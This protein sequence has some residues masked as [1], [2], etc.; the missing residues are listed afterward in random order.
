MRNCWGKDM[1]LQW[2]RLAASGKT[3]GIAADK[4]CTVD[5]TRRCIGN[6]SSSARQQGLRNAESC[7]QMGQECY[8]C[9]GESLLSEA[10]GPIAAAV[11]YRRGSRSRI[12]CPGRK[13]SLVHRPIGIY[14]RLGGSPCQEC[15]LSCAGK[16]AN[17]KEVVLV[18]KVRSSP[19][20]HQ[21]F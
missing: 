3:L 11:P 6:L 4:C 18:F 2:E 20:E 17:V 12:G 21:F 16:Q 10:A 8:S 19:G 14:A 15:F 7:E 9:Q 13:I 1:S 5:R